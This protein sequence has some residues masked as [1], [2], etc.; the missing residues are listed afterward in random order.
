MN[1]FFYLES[2]I[3]Q[4]C[5]LAMYSAYDFNSQEQKHYTNLNNTCDY[6]M[7]IDEERKCVSDAGKKIKST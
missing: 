2:G 1:M 6:I 7:Q 4:Y 3:L 5:V